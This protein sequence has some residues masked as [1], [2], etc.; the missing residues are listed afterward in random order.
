MGWR[1][2]APGLTAFYAEFSKK[3]EMARTDPTAG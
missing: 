2:K 3:P 1:A